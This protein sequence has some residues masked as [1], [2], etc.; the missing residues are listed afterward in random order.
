MGIYLQITFPS[1]PISS[2]PPPSGTG[3][4]HFKS[5]VIADGFSPDFRR[6]SMTS[7]WAFT[8]ELGAHFPAF[9]DF[10]IHSSVRGCIASR[11]RYI[12][13]EAL[14]TTLWLVLSTHRGLMSSIASRV[15]EQPSHWSPRASY[16]IKLW[17]ILISTR[18]SYRIRA[19]W[20]SPFSKTI[21]QEPVLYFTVSSWYLDQIETPTFDRLHNIAARFP[22][23]PAFHSFEG[24]RTHPV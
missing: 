5:R 8:T 12:C 23:S 13:V 21:S 24:Q 16:G 7:P 18:D 9:H 22:F 4:P 2:S 15:R 1:V 14:V 20:A 6:P 11:R 10:E 17:G 3:T 19:V